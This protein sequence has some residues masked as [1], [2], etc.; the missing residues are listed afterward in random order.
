MIAIL[1]VGNLARLG[2]L[3]NMTIAQFAAAKPVEEDDNL[4]KVE[5]ADH[6][7]KKTYGSA[8]ILMTQELKTY[9]ER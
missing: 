2:A 7:T 5:V 3:R 6:K 4:V 9:V 8:P 1:A